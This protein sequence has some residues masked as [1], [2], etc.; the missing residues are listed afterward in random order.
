[1]SQSN[2]VNFLHN[3]L[4]SPIWGTFNTQDSL[5]WALFLVRKN[6]YFSVRRGRHC[7]VSMQQMMQHAGRFC[8][9]GQLM[10][11]SNDAG[12]LVLRRKSQRD[13]VFI[14]VTYPRQK[15]AVNSKTFM[16]T[17]HQS[18]TCQKMAQSSKMIGHP[19]W[20]S[21]LSAPY[22]KHG[23][24]SNMGGENDSGNPKTHNSRFMCCIRFIYRQWRTERGGGSNSLPTKFRR[25]S[26]IVPNSTWLWKLLKIAEFRTPAPQDIKKKME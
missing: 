14:A 17:W 20:W 23:R 7:M 3:R 24:D 9:W 15:F 19:Q 22:I 21:C 11:N 6:F 25:P 12:N 8:A 13:S 10:C 4:S 1:M 16:V 26:K 18:E 5:A 2:F